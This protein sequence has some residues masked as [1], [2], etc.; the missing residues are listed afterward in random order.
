MRF[1]KNLLLFILVV[2]VLLAGVAFV[3]PGSA[4]VERSITINRPASEVHAILNSYRR[5]NEWSPWAAK[6]PNAKYVVSGPVSGVGAKESWVGNPDTVGSGSQ[7]IIESTPNQSVTTQ[8]KFG[9]MF[10]ARAHFGLAADTAATNTK[11]LWTF[12]SDA[13]LPLDGKIIWN[14]VGRYMGLFTEKMVGPDYEH[15][16]AS[17]KL[18]V[19]GL[20]AADISGVQGEETQRA[21]QKIYFV[22]ASSG[23]DAQ[24]AKAVL[25][26]AYTKI[27]EFLKAN[28]VAMQ[29]APMTITDS[30]DASGWKF[31]AAIPVD[32]NEAAASGDVKS[33]ESYAGKAVQFVHT[34]SYETIGDTVQKAYAW[35]AVQ[36]YKPKGRLIEEYI[37]DPGTTPAEQLKTRLV[38]PV[39]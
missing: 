13:P 2:V 31:D 39:E 1:L 19:E 10:Q 3:L 32:R 9:E 27:G 26:D 16:L 34:G 18:L 5:F 21:A 24:A 23:A 11:V 6:D 25:T 33:G 17:L 14:I 20:P 35:L 30:Y 12:D 7:E 29:G 8:L 15:G 4:H 37:S 28:G 38:I 36:A 22:S